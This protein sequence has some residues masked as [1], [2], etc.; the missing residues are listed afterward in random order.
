MSSFLHS[1]NLQLDSTSHTNTVRQ[2][3]S[4]GNN[5][6]ANGGRA[7]SDSSINTKGDGFGVGQIL[8]EQFRQPKLKHEYD[9]E[10]N[11]VGTNGH[12][13][14]A[15]RQENE[16][17]SCELLQKDS[18]AGF[19]DFSDTDVTDNE[20]KLADDRIIDRHAQLI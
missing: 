12:Q 7:F 16:K 19:S 6:R 5:R 17:D 3:S 18:E 2:P 13:K 8:G 9:A 14:Q 4:V 15:I 1:G 10:F 11:C 20:V